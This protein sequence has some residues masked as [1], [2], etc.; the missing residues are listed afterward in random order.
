MSQRRVNYLK[1]ILTRDESELIRQV[2]DAQK[3][4]SMQGDFAKL[5][6]KDLESFGLTHDQVASSEMTKTALKKKTL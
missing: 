4:A 3:R 2:Y 5:V 1:H 6:A